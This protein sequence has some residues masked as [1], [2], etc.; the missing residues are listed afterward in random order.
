MNQRPNGALFNAVCARFGHY[1]AACRLFSAF[2]CYPRRAMTAQARQNLTSNKARYLAWIND[3]DR[4]MH[5]IAVNG[6]ASG[7][8]SAGGGSQSYT[9]LDLDKLRKLRSDYTGR[10]TQIQR[11]LAGIPSV[12]V[13]RIMTVRY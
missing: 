10:I 8:V 7:S 1:F 4:I 2:L 5:E 9:R 6:A 3:I 11:R 13:R 12:G